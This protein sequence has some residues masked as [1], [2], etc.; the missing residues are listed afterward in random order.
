MEVGALDARIDALAGSHELLLDKVELG[1]VRCIRSKAR[2]ALGN[3]ID[4]REPAPNGPGQRG[5]C[6]V[7]DREQQ[8][9]R[10]AV[11][12]RCGSIRSSERDDGCHPAI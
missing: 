7:R 3:D 5:R 4:G 1:V 6:Q 8:V 2:L 11:R 12:V 9:D 10:R